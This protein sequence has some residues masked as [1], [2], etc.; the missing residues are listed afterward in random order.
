MQGLQELINCDFKIFLLFY[1]SSNK[2]TMKS[3]TLKVILLLALYPVFAQDDAS[4]P[5]GGSTASLP[6]SSFHINPLGL[7][8]FG[9]V[10]MYESRMGSGTT[11]IAPYFRYGY[12]GLGTHLDWNADFVSP[13]NLGFGALIKSYSIT[14]DQS[15]ALYYG[16]GLELYFGSANYDV[17]TQFE[18]IERY[19][20]LPIVGN[21]GYR[22]RYPTKNIINLGIILGAAITLSDEETFV[23]DGSLYAEYDET[24][25]FGMLEFSFGWEK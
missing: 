6:Q 23:S 11:Y 9:P 25:F 12:L 10:F 7:L 8:Q 3:I 24:T 13:V 1:F 22:W 17:D 14:G 4:I 2:T 19:V 20:G 21:F 15:N 18:T 16:G 5:G